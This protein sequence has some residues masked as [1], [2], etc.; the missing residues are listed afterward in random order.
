MVARR[1]ARR[2]SRAAAFAPGHL[3][4]WFAP[5]L[6]ASDPR[7]RGSIGEGIVL[8]AGAYAEATSD[9]T[10]PHRVRVA[11]PGLQE[12][13][14]SLDVAERLWARG[15]GSLHVNIHHELPVGCGLGMSA[16][17]AVATARAVGQLVGAR[18]E[19]AMQ[20]AHLAEL[21]GGGGL[22]GV[23]AIGGGGLERRER[24]GV[25]PWGRVLRRPAR[26]EIWIV[27]ADGPLPTPPLLA[28]SRFLARVD[29]A[30]EASSVGALTLSGVAE[31]GQS[32]T[33]R[34][35]LL[36][37]SSFR[38]V[39][40]LRRAGAWCGQ[41]MLGRTLWVVIPPTADPGPIESMLRRGRGTVARVPIASRGARVL[42]ETHGPVAQGL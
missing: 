41:A 17:G 18:G 33:D 27:L 4:T 15:A 1:R 34:L 32:F 8:E 9:P 38:R 31:R 22:G 26:G 14:I 21:Y 10:A 12:L 39:R 28:S 19:A 25:P 29:R 11:A 36:A 20:V 7:A 16:A 5:R 3:T 40:A 24:P 37:P 35:G 13:P 2:H 23:A 6:A 30:A 42:P